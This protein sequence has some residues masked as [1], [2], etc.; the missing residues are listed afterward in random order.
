[1]QRIP[2]LLHV[3]LFYVFD[4]APMMKHCTST[5]LAQDHFYSDSSAHTQ[6]IGAITSSE[7]VQTLLLFQFLEILM[8]G[9]LLVWPSEGG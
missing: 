8:D 2:R 9:P 7:D 1:M 6:S 5:V 3:Y 4:H